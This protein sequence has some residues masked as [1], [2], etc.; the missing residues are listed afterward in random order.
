MFLFSLIVK[1]F[2]VTL[3]FKDEEAR[4]FEYYYEL[5]LQPESKQLSIKTKKNK[6]NFFLL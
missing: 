1:L 4:D 3:K 5:D 2:L 6:S